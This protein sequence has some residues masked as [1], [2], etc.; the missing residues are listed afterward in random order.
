MASKISEEKGSFCRPPVF[1]DLLSERVLTVDCGWSM[2]S[3]ELVDYVASS[4]IIEN[5]LLEGEGLGGFRPSNLSWTLETLS[6]I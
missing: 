4:S 6:V 2:E 5:K 3:L 1:N